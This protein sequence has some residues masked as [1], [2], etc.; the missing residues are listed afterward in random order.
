M[1]DNLALMT[2]DYLFLV[3]NLKTSERIWPGLFIST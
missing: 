3:D 2:A 1:R